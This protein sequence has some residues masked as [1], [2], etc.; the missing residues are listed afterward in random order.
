MVFFEKTRAEAP[1]GATAGPPGRAPRN[2]PPACN[3]VIA[4]VNSQAGTTTL[5]QSPAPKQ[6]HLRTRSSSKV[7]PVACQIATRC[8]SDGAATP[9]SD[10][11]QLPAHST[12]HMGSWLVGRGSTTHRQAA[13]QIDVHQQPQCC[14]G[15]EPAKPVQDNEMCTISLCNCRGSTD[16]QRSNSTHTCLHAWAS[17]AAAASIDPVRAMNRCTRVGTLCSGI[18]VLLCGGAAGSCTDSVCGENARAA[19][20]GPLAGSRA[21]NPGT[22]QQ[23]RGCAMG[24]PAYTGT[25]CLDT[26]TP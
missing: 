8:F 26:T 6:A 20:F 19:A 21:G 1:P 15:L 10:K 13:S 12:Q 18:V 9:P 4:L 14:L 7:I 11:M 23:E 25:P 2:P 22:M 5:K 3:K 24:C 17:A 16:S